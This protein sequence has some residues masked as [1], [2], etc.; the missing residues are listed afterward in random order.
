MKYKTFKNLITVCINI[1][2]KEEE[3]SK[4]LS[5]VYSMDGGDSSIMMCMFSKEIDLIINIIA[6]AVEMDSKEAIDWINYLIYDALLENSSLTFKK[7]D[8]VYESNTKNIWKLLN[9]KL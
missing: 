1:I 5:E 7:E 2:E 4:K 9:K 3:L 6:T 8:V